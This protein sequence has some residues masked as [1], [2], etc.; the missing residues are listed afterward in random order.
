MNNLCS[1]NMVGTARFEL[2][3]PCTPCKCATRLRY[4]PFARIIGSGL[5]SRT[6]QAADR[7]QLLSHLRRRQRDRA[8]RLVL[9]TVAFTRRRVPIAVVLP[10]DQED[11]MHG[12][13]AA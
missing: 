5:G 8:D 10:S 11:T 1:K 12:K 3:T 2:A 7:E 13:H 4:A 9:G 6:E